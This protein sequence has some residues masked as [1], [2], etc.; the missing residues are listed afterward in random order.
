VPAPRNEQK[1]QMIKLVKSGRTITEA[2]ALMKAA[3]TGLHP[4]YTSVKD[5]KDLAKLEGINHL[6]MT[7][8]QATKL[9]DLRFPPP[10]SYPSTREEA[11]AKFASG[12]RGRIPLNWKRDGNLIRKG[13]P[14][15]PQP[16]SSAGK[17]GKTS[18]VGA[19]KTLKD[20]DKMVGVLLELQEKHGKKNHSAMKKAFKS[21]RT[22][23]SAGKAP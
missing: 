11:I 16:G 4:E 2:Q 8:K 6:L 18:V 23:V 15:K 22:S 17:I 3:S 14:N 9:M 5:L 10:R 20:F 7:R 19:S 1:Y 21:I 13:P 12:Y